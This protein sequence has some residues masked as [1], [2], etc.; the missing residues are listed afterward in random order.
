MKM[1][2]IKLGKEINGMHSYIFL[3]TFCQ[4]CTQFSFPPIPSHT[5]APSS[6]Y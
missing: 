1:L 6:I 3:F 2:L 5:P 4:Q